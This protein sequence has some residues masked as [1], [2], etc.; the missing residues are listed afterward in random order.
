MPSAWS[1]FDHAT[2]LGNA[3]VLGTSGQECRELELPCFRLLCGVLLLLFDYILS[4]GIVKRF[5]LLFLVVFDIC[6]KLLVSL[7]L[8]RRAGRSDDVSAYIVITYA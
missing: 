1:A 3:C 8:R 6:C 4:I 7:G 5:A 2:T